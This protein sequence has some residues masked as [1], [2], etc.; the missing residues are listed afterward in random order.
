MKMRT[1]NRSYFPYGSFF[2]CSVSL[3]G[4]QGR[5]WNAGPEGE[6]LADDF[7]EFVFGCTAAEGEGAGEVFHSSSRSK[8]IISETGFLG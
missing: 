8:S 5:V 4:N 1:F 6:G 2:A 7:V 3:G